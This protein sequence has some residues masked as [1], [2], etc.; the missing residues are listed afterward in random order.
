MVSNPDLPEYRS[1]CVLRIRQAFQGC[2]R[3][4]P[5]QLAPDGGIDGPSVIENWKELERRDVEALQYFTSSFAED[6]SYMS[7]MALRYYLPAVMVLILQWPGRIDFG[8]F[9]S[10]ISR[11]E[12]LFACGKAHQWYRPIALTKSQIAACHDWFDQLIGIIKLFD[13]ESFEDEYVQRLED[14]RSATSKGV[15]STDYDA[16]RFRR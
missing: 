1:A 15:A 4:R 5:E 3:P 16:E 6:L 14:L 10:V 11:F 2:P 12:G 9:I 8:E 7:S 13:L